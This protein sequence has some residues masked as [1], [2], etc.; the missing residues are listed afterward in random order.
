MPQWDFRSQQDTRRRYPI[1]WGRVFISEL[2]SLLRACVFVFVSLFMH[3]RGA[4]FVS[5]LWVYQ[6]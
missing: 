1:T 3:D 5:N 4:G 2:S 6:C